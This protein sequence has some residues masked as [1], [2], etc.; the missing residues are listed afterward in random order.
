MDHIRHIFL[1]KQV[2]SKSS[3]RFKNIF[4]TSLLNWELSY[5]LNSGHVWFKIAE[6]NFHGQP[7]IKNEEEED[8]ELHSFHLNII[9]VTF[10]FDYFENFGC[11]NTTIAEK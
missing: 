3:L 5:I 9:C 7:Q 2:L 6:F 4:S 11:V 1:L 10:F 8:H